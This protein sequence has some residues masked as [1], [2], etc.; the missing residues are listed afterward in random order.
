MGPSP[1]MLVFSLEEM[2]RCRET[3]EFYCYWPAEKC[4]R[5]LRA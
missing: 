1:F 5:R 2:A 4:A 3:D